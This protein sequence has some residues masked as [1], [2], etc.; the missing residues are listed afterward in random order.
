MFYP[1]LTPAYNETRQT[2]QHKHIYKHNTR[3]QR[4]RIWG[5][6]VNQM[7]VIRALDLVQ[8]H[9]VRHTGLEPWLSLCKE[10]RAIVDGLVR[11]VCLPAEDVASLS[12]RAWPKLSTLKVFGR[13]VGTL[14]PSAVFPSTAL[15]KFSLDDVYE[16]ALQLLSHVV[17]TSSCITTLSLSRSFVGYGDL[18]SILKRLKQLEELHLNH[19]FG[20]CLCGSITEKMAYVK[21]CD[22]L[23]RLTITHCSFCNRGSS[24]VLKLVPLVAPWLRELNL[25]GNNMSLEMVNL[26]RLTACVQGMPNLE[27]V[28]LSN[29][30]LDGNTI[31]AFCNV[32]E[33]NVRGNDLTVEDIDDIVGSAPTWP[34]L[35]KINIG[36]NSLSSDAVDAL[37]AWF[38]GCPQLEEIS[39]AHNML[40]PEI[41]RAL[42][43][44]AA[45]A[46]RLDLHSISLEDNGIEHMA[47]HPW[48][49]LCWLDLSDNELYWTNTNVQTMGLTRFLQRCPSLADLSLAS[50][51]L[52]SDQIGSIE[53]AQLTS[54][55]R[56]DVSAT[57]LTESSLEKLPM[58]CPLLERV[59]IEHNFLDV[60]RLS[61]RVRGLVAAG[62]EASDAVPYDSLN[63][64]M[65]RLNVQP[66]VVPDQEPMYMPLGLFVLMYHDYCRQRDL[67]AGQLTEKVL[68]SYLQACQL[69]LDLSN[70]VQLYPREQGVNVGTQWIRGVDSKTP[71]DMKEFL[72]A[73]K[74]IQLASIDMSN[75]IM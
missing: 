46:I 37:A 57:A 50:N 56:L 72:N 12:K 19:V 7:D 15:R 22:R 75:A 13:M 33:L 8:E 4:Q 17:K 52:D 66:D 69:D 51:F 73:L 36:H 59:V 39:V 42:R 10:A 44:A 40:G 47:A 16:E 25:S 2:P 49:K 61:C 45:R 58:C 9:V 1:I 26:A 60:S 34:R 6:L 70:R 20:V 67:E 24:I 74:D 21:K 28:N 35:K 54:L 48:P 23:K 3:T 53:A 62:R 38:D 65:T 43:G 30:L 64:F 71:P 27:T 18:V 63:A 29:N 11:S 68:R 55:R 41:H 14:D 32:V 5:V 31:S